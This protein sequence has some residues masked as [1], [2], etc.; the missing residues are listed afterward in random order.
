[1]SKREYENQEVQ[2][3]AKKNKLLD[4]LKEKGAKFLTPLDEEYKKVVEESYANLSL[5]QSNEICRDLRDRVEWAFQVLLSEGYLY[6]D[7][8]KLKSRTVITPVSRTLI[9]QPGLTYKYLNLRL[10]TLPWCFGERPPR[11]E[12]EE[13]CAVFKDLND[14]FCQH[15]KD[16]IIKKCAK[17]K[18]EDSKSVDLH[19]DDIGK[20]TRQD[21]I[22]QLIERNSKFTVTL[23]NY[24]DP[25]S[26]HMRCEPYYSMGRLA[27]SWHKDEN[28]MTGSTVAVYNHSC[29]EACQD[30]AWKV[31][32]KVAWD[33]E[34]PAIAVPLY[35]GDCYCMLDGMNDTHQHCVVAGTAPRFSSTHRVTES[36]TSTLSYIQRQV[37][38]ALQNMN[39]DNDGEEELKSLNVE[40]LQLTE[41]VHNEVEFEWIRQFWMQG[42]QHAT[43]REYWIKPMED[44]E[45]D[46]KKL[47][48]MTKLAIDVVLG[49]NND[50][51]E[52]VAA[53]LP[54]ITER[55]ELRNQW[56][57]RFTGEELCRIPVEH[58]PDYRPH[59]TKIDSSLPLPFDLTDVIVQLQSISEPTS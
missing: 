22:D 32:L 18:I 10:F 35:N 20:E 51:E 15:V 36:S 11:N 43:E 59:W 47:E 34:T 24:M 25:S 5:Q 3:K 19:Q 44:L 52:I 57:A 38:E 31:G 49:E 30:D 16:L 21:N 2:K 23:L 37:E 45:R 39:Q 50:K 14:Y 13:A 40:I 12:V 29:Q 56:M 33:T 7:R 48:L 55:Q 9:G 1:M 4:D 6:Q 27:V 26:V 41:E 54:E 42:V 58:T 46:W 17:L 28:L 53:I 8:V